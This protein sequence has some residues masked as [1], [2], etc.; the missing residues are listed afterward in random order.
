MK[1]H[2]QT[3]SQYNLWA[4]ECI[5]GYI[6][7]AGEQ[8]A[9]TTLTSSFPSIRK[10]LYHVWDAQYIWMKRLN[11]ESLNS[12]PSHDFKGTLEEGIEGLLESSCDFVRFFE[13]MPENGEKRMV[14]YHAIDKT[15]YH[16]SVEE[17]IMH[18]MNHGTYHRGQLITMLRSSGFEQLGSTDY[19]RFL[20]VKK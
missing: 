16:N 9:D 18:V 5:C 20:R 2:L 4:N 10:T 6:K 15:S 13:N 19:I 8:R 11:G 7:E 14:E 1:N 12:W 3:L 17:I